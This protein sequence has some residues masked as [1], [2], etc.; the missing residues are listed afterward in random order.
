MDAV[1]RAYR[2]IVRRDADL[3]L[4][5]DDSGTAVGICT[6][7]VRSTM[8][9]ESL[10]AWI[11]ELVVSEPL[12]GRGIGRA[13]LEAGISTARERGARQAVLESGEQRTT[14]Q[15]L[16]RSL[17]FLPAGSVFTLLRDR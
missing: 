4:I 7:E 11:P 1:E 13:L 17:G 6:V 10:E 3:S 2:E 5:A 8:R 15:A 9:Q 14:A 12:R 16:Y